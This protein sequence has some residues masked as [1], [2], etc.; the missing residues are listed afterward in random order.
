MTEMC[1][2]LLMVFLP[3]GLGRIQGNRMRGMHILPP[4]ILENIFDVPVYNFSLIWSLFDSNK[5]YAISTHNLIENVRT[6][7]IIFG[8]TLKTWVKKFEQNLAENCS[9]STKITIR[10]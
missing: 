7:C 10:A 2:T 9:K 1:Q 5:P 6:K 8:E 4:A 3:Y